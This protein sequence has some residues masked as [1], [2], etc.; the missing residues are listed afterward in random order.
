VPKVLSLLAGPENQVHIVD[1]GHSDL[2]VHALVELPV[3]VEQ[4]TL[5]RL[6]LLLRL[7]V[8][9]TS[10]HIHSRGH[11]QVRSRHVLLPVVKLTLQLLTLFLVFG[12]TTLVVQNHRRNLLVQN[13]LASAGN[14]LS[15]A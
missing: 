7:L 10:R 3:L 12:E 15:D 6:V 2:V 13:V 4:L 5:L 1:D 9:T 8:L 11:V 14:H